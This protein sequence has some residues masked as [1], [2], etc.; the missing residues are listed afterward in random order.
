[1]ATLKTGWMKKLINGVSEK[2]FAISHVKSVYYNYAEKKTLANKLDEID[3]QLSSVNNWITLVDWVTE[4]SLENG[5]GT[6]TV[7]NLI[8]YKTLSFT[9]SANNSA[10][11]W[12]KTHMIPVTLFRENNA[13]MIDMNP[14]DL[15]NHLM[16]LLSYNSDTSVAL[17]I[18]KVGWSS[19]PFKVKVMAQA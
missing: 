5:V 17:R 2:I 18:E 12:S 10:G 14:F 6:Y 16:A 1:M 4:A 11:Y 15:N 7:S 13:V 9:C 19:E 8:N 3:N